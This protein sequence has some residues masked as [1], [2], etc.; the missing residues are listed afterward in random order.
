ML[1]W[2]V[3][4]VGQYLV[5]TRVL[6]RARVDGSRLNRNGLIFCCC[7]DMPDFGLEDSRYISRVQHWEIERELS[8]RG[9]GHV[10]IPSQ[11]RHAQYIDPRKR[12]RGNLKCPFGEMNRFIALPW[13]HTLEY[14]RATPLETPRVSNRG[15]MTAR[16][17]KAYPFQSQIRSSHWHQG[18]KSP[19]KYL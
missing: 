15:G 18:V 19:C 6:K 2:H 10:N 13:A 9:D 8:A 1:L 17:Q 7:D 16:P 5:S 3:P 4:S 12:S 11:N 14:F